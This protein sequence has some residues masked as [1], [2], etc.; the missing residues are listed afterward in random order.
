MQGFMTWFGVSVLQTGSFLD[1][2]IPF[3]ELTV[4][5]LLLLILIGVAIVVAGLV[6][7]A[8]L[9]AIFRGTPLPENMER[10]VARTSLYLVVIVGLLFIPSVFGIN[11]GA[12]DIFGFSL[13]AILTAVVL[14]IVFYLA[15]NI[16]SGVLSRFFQKTGYPEDI[17][18]ALVGASRLL[19]YIVGVFVVFGIL[20]MDLTALIISFGAFSIALSFALAD[21][22]KNVTS[23]LLI[24]ADKPFYPGDTI[25]VGGIEGKVIKTKIRS[26]VLETEEGHIAYIPNLWFTT[27]D[28]I[29]K[30]RR[31]KPE[32]SPE[33]DDTTDS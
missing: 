3:L 29:N 28:I 16:V 15:A 7:R 31:R 11:L 27:K 24:Q 30:T 17:V 8:A 12:I 13:S 26:T 4:W 22:I 33:T 23:G 6:V 32:R 19:V 1:T 18:K 21:I 10:R 2:K 14:A 25:K 20:G 9:M 5:Q